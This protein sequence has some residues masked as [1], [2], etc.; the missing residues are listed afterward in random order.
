MS[1]FLEPWKQPRNGVINAGP[2]KV[3]AEPTVG[4][5]HKKIARRIVAAVNACAGLPT[6]TLEE[7]SQAG[8]EAFLVNLEA[9]RKALS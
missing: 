5:G 8:P 9:R 7:L 1:E 2:V 4:D 6:E 3:T